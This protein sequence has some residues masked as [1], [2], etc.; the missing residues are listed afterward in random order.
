MTGPLRDQLADYLA[1]RRALGY[2]LERPEKLLGQF[3]GHLEHDGETVITV[4]SALAWAQLPAGGDS[5]WRA[6]RLSVVRGFATYLHAI[7]PVHE[8]PAAGLLPQRPLRASPYLYSDAE[9]AALIAA[10]ATLRTPLRRATFAT[11]I[12]LLS[13][14]GIRIGEAISLDRGDVDLAGGRL[15]I[16][17]G[18]FGKT[19]EL[20]LHPSAVQALRNYRQARDRSAPQTGTPAFFVS[21]AG[22]R[23]IYCNVHNT[24]HRLVRHIGLLPRS[25]S[26]RPRIHDLRHTFAVRAML[27]AYAAGEDGQARLTLLSAW[28]GHVHPDNT[29]WYLSAAPELMALAGQRLEALLTGG[30]EARS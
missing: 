18:K 9:V 10:T 5:N 1:L 29:Y 7:D 24:F 21:A 14:T 8:V 2:R 30:P 27:D 12:G 20:A 25:P 22:T 26:C 19:R 11:L 4:P 17:F 3:L 16:R 15:T 6:Y 23:L 28:L 13:V